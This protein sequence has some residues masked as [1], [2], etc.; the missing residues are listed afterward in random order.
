MPHVSRLGSAV[1]E[2]AKQAKVGAAGAD[3]FSMGIMWKLLV[4]ALSNALGQVL[5]YYAIK[6]LLHKGWGVL[7]NRNTSVNATVASW[8]SFGYP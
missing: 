5:I 8:L 6:D 3:G 4:L 1:T 7:V 2:C